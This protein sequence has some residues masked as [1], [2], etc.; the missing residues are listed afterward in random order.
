MERPWQAKYS[1]QIFVWDLA[2]GRQ[3]RQITDPLRVPHG[4]VDRLGAA[5]LPSLSA[6]GK[7]PG[8]PHVEPSGSSCWA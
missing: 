1:G 6:R 2:E 3:V 4:L 5:P 7:L 8:L